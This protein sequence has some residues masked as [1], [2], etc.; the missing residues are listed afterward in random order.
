M[1][2]R[3]PSPGWADACFRLLVSLFPRDFRRTYGAEIS[4]TVS[5]TLRKERAARGWVEFRIVLARLTADFGVRLAIEHWRRFCSAVRTPNRPIDSRPSGGRMSTFGNDLRYSLRRLLKSPGY[6]AVA[7]MTLALAMGANATIFGFVDA[8]LLQPL[9]FQQPERLVSLWESLPQRSLPRYRV[10]SHDFLQWQSQSRSFEE[11]ALYRRASFLMRNSD[12]VSLIYGSQV[13]RGF[14]QVLKAQPLLGRT[15]TGAD[16]AADAQPAVVL[17]HAAWVRRFSADPA[18]IGASI[19]LSDSPWTVVGVMPRQILP[20]AHQASGELLISRDQEWIWAPWPILPNTHSHVH[21]ALARLAPGVSLQQASAEMDTVAQRLEREFPDSN[22]GVGV[23]LVPLSQEI[24]GAVEG[25]LLALLAA[26]AMLTLI[27]CANVANLTLLRADS[28]RREIALRAALGA[29]RLRIL[30]QFLAEGALLALAGA[31]LGLPA[32]LAGTRLLPALSPVDIPRLDEAGLSLP[33]LALTLGVCLAVMAMIGLASGLRLGERMESGLREGGRGVSARFGLQRLLVAAETGLAVVL[34]ICA[35]LLTSSFQRLQAVD[36]G[37]EAGDVLVLTLLHSPERYSE[38]HRLTEF[39]ERLLE[40]VAALPGVLSVSASYD[41]PMEANWTQGFGI[42]GVPPP[43]PEQG[44]LALF[45]TV[46][47]GYFRTMGL[48]LIQGRSFRPGDGAD[49]PGAAIVNQSFVDRFL[50]GRNPLGQRLTARTTQWQWGDEIPNAFDIVGVVGDVKF[51]GL[52][53]SSQ[54]AYYLPFAQ[55][56]QFKMALLVRTRSDPMESLPA[57][58]SKLRTLDAELPLAQIDTIENILYQ[59]VAQPRFGSLTIGLFA[60][61]AWFMATAGLWGVLSHATRNRLHE[62]GLRMAL[63]AG[64][65][66]IFA[67]LLGHGMK[68]ALAGT[69]LG[70]ASALAVSRLLNSML[71]ETDPADPF[72]YVLV[73]AV[74]LGVAAAACALPARTAA[75][76]DPMR[77]LRRE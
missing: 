26:V 50:E 41:H 59:S 69:L 76:T 46:S 20:L 5:E 53:A 73:P 65:T 43:D 40:E 74:L 31:A 71:F 16:F 2:P 23:L 61:A 39:Y 3:P 14:F 54:P 10:S 21:G 48:D 77:V 13:S 15:L 55:T 6:S 51:S 22:R 29:G 47:P 18:I 56:P 34:L 44:R 42:E 57:I 45:R 70:A 1:N 35:A 17:S 12:G 66:R 33:V 60:A 75:R 68:P 36:P 49:A 62:I 4:L 7:I 25:T 19:T 28:R 9:P 38:M 58:R 8:V 67:H 72:I 64:R 52:A 27:A 37:F 32:A 11:M 30:R 63:G 24:S